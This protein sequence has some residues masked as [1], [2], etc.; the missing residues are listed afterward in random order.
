MPGPMRQDVYGI[1]QEVRFW[2]IEYV[3]GG[4]GDPAEQLRLKAVALI[5]DWRP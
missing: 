5:W 3:Q 1:D 4:A 2:R